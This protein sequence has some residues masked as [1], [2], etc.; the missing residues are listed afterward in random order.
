VVNSHAA[1]SGLLQRGGIFHRTPKYRIESS[2]QKW[3]GKHYRAGVSW[4][5]V[6]EAVLAVYF[7]F[8]TT[9][10]VLHGMWL[11]IPFLLLFVQGYGYMSLL[12]ILPALDG[13]RVAPTGLAELGDGW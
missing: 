5:F 9:Y 4:S 10:A 2:G 7:A 1:I 13:L 8:C 11:S 12:S 3:R 6:V